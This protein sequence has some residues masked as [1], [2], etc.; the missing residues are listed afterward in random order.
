MVA[1][2]PLIAIQILGLVYKIKHA[3]AHREELMPADQVVTDSEGQVIIDF[4]ALGQTSDANEN[5]DS[6]ADDDDDIIDF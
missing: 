5:T 2:T 3:A 4:D 6:V 1:M